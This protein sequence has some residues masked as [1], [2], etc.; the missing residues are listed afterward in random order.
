MRPPPLT[1]LAAAVLHVPV[2]ERALEIECGEGEGTLFL[3]RE[4][5]RARVRGADSSAASIRA[6]SSRVGLDPEGRIAFRAATPRR[7][8]YPDAHFD[9][10][11]QRRGLAVLAETARVLRPGGL[12]LIAAGLRGR[13]P[14]G[15][16]LSLARLLPWHG[17]EP[18]RQAAGEFLLSRLPDS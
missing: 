3:S 10:V 7:L 4:F 6:A 1:P 12:L 13:G 9:L 5:P 18:A 15:I 14:L 2:P 8:P 17:F 16:P 11:V